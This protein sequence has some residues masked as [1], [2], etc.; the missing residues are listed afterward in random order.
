LYDVEHAI[1]KGNQLSVGKR[2][3]GPMRHAMTIEIITQLNEM[4]KEIDKGKR[5]NRT[6]LHRL[7]KNLIT[8]ATTGDDLFDEHGE[9]IKEGTGDL[10]AITEIINRVEGKPAQR[11]TGADDGPVQVEYKTIEEVRMFLLERGIDSLRAPPPSMKVI[12]KD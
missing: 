9:L 1:R 3:L 12:S 4:A 5:V 7:V 8:K 2:P 11:I 10:Q 6:K